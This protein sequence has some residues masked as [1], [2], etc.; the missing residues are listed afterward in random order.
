MLLYKSMGKYS[1][2][3]KLVS[4]YYQQMGILWVKSDKMSFASGSTNS[5]SNV[6]SLSVRGD[7]GMVPRAI[8]ALGAPT[9]G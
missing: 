6:V 2:T 4:S 8:E 7:V 3:R 9:K 1:V 5:S